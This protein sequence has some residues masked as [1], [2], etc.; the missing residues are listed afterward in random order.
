MNFKG[1]V[2]VIA[3]LILTVSC[4][5][6][7]DSVMNDVNAEMTASADTYASL[8]FNVGIGAATKSA[9]ADGTEA[10]TA[11]ETT[12]SNCIMIITKGNASNSKITAI[13]NVSGS[14]LVYNSDNT[15][16]V[17]AN[18]V[19][20][21]TSDLYVTAIANADYSTFASCSTLG[22][23]QSKKVSLN[24]A[25]L[26]KVSST[27]AVGTIPSEYQSAH[28]TDLKPYTLPTI[29]LNQ[30]S[31][32]VELVGFNYSYTGETGANM[33]EPTV[34]LVS[35]SLVNAKTTSYLYTQDSNATYTT[36]ADQKLDSSLK[37]SCYTFQNSDAS[38]KTSLQLTVKVGNKTTTKTYTV[39]TPNGTSYDEV[40]KA[41]YIYKVTVNLTVNRILKIFDVTLH[42]EAVPMDQ[43]TVNVPT[44]D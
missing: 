16:S 20:K 34:E 6:E 32:K 3:S 14:N 26:V 28:T 18:M 1:I 35:T 23:V 36:I 38:N 8:T 44:F 19:V 13:T 41:G 2:L 10:G 33:E 40:V 30:L 21:A 27:I 37:F 15:W 17:N 24:A 31:A 39:K 25:S 9:T 4:S 7:N 43:I 12:L 29:S 22:E 5:V 42:Y 11:A